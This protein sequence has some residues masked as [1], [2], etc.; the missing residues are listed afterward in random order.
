MTGKRLVLLGAGGH[1]K[2]VA[3]AAAASGWS[4]VG[5]LDPGREP[6]ER[7]LGLPV[8]GS[9]EDLSDLTGCCDAFLPA[10]GDAVIRWREFRRLCA[11]GL[12]PATVIH[13]AAWVSPTAR[14]GGGTVVMA[15]AVVQAET[16]IGEAAIVNTR[17]SVDH[18]CRIGDGVMIAPGATLCGGVTIGDHAFVGA[19]AIVVPGIVIGRSAFV[20]AGT[21]VV[22]DVPE[23]GRIKHV[24]RPAG[25]R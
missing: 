23:N 11:A 18:D 12:R 3:E 1:A 9:G 4:V 22:A 6:G 7:V 24:R 15:G 25:S 20:G 16:R 10:I 2:V 13:P 5:F 21:T 19:G 17:A 8:V 14:I